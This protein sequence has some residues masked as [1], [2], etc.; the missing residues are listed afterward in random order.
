MLVVTSTSLAQVGMDSKEAYEKD[1]E[2][3]LLAESGS[4]YKRKVC[5]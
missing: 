3:H 5:A 1:F 4:Y 2:E